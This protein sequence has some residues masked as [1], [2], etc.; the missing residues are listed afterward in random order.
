MIIV[1]FSEL[2]GADGFAERPSPSG[3]RLLARRFLSE[4]GRAEAVRLAAHR[5]QVVGTSVSDEQLVD[6]IAADLQWG[7]LR[8]VSTGRAELDGSLA[9][10]AWITAKLGATD[11]ST[12]RIEPGRWQGR[13][14]KIPVPD[15]EAAAR[16]VSEIMAVREGLTRLQSVVAE[17]ARSPVRLEG[18]ALSRAAATMLANG[19]IG[20]FQRVDGG[21]E[22]RKEEDKKPVDEGPRPRPIVIPGPKGPPPVRHWVEIELK[23]EDGDPLAK[24]P[25]EITLADGTVSAGVLDENGRARLDGVAAGQCKVSFPQIDAREWRPA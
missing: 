14:R 3:A 1:R 22:G 19:T 4:R 16:F 17:Q 5:R 18:P 13:G 15:K 9:G 25:Y 20:L 11:G 2:I 21:A 24:E 7:V 8:L 10:E 23:D 12:F 6:W